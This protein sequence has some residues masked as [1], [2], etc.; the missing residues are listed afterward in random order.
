LTIN[1]QRKM[2]RDMVF[3]I[4]IS[5]LASH[6]CFLILPKVFEPW[7]AQIIDQ[8]FV[9]RDSIN[10][11]R[12][13]YDRTLIHVDINNSAVQQLDNFYLNRA[14][15][16]RVIN[17]LAAMKSAVEAFDF[18]FAARTNAKDDKRLIDATKEAGNV[19]FGLAFS[20]SDHPE[21]LQSG[22]KSREVLRYLDDVKWRVDLK[23]DASDFYS[24]GEPLITFPALSKS[25]RGIGFISIK[26]DRDGVFRRVPLL[27][28]Y[29][30]GFFPSFPFRVVCDYL[31]VTPDRIIVRP[32]KNITLKD[33]GK[34]GEKPHDIVIPIDSRG[35][36]IINFVGPWESMEH[37]SFSDIYRASED[38]DEMEMWKE[39]LAGKIVLVS[40]VST[41]SS[42]IGPVPTDLN[43]PL[44]GLHANVINTIL[45]GQF[46]TQL[47][48][49]DGVLIE[50][51]PMGVIFLLSLGLSSFVYPIGT[52][53]LAVA[54]CGTAAL[55][56]FYG[57]TIF[58]VLGP[59][60]LIVFATVLVIT[61]RYFAE[62]KEKAVYRKTFEAYFP[63]SIVKKLVSNPELISSKGQKKELTILFS[64]IKSFT[65]Y[66]A[67]LTPDQI[68]K[69]LNDYFEA[70]VDIVFGFEGTVDKYIGDGLMVFFGDP[71]PQP[72]HAIRCVR[73][74]IEMQRK[75]IKLAE[76]WDGEKRIPIQIRIGV[77][78]GEV[79]VG[80]MGS[81]RRLSYTV[82]GAP[83]NLA[84]R[85]E[86]NAPVGGIMI[87]RRTRDLVKDQVPTRSL[88]EIRVKGI[89]KPV[90]VY[91]VLLDGESADAGEPGASASVS[92]V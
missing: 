56:F 88:G 26:P 55:A 60:L 90:E 83:V 22:E 92:A 76:D 32:G 50:L 11:L 15:Y 72:D 3:L 82:L 17:N 4:M 29:N 27:V 41:A 75:V 38:R 64:D 45:T 84:Q 91:E 20:L 58:P 36:M 57:G 14:H 40:D 65:T 8:L 85:L 77:N 70:M 63:P 66:S 67:D 9:L 53:S 2:K 89:D 16:A 86:A 21:R 34:P 46:L 71:E 81:E 49:L 51:L 33:A 25:A 28:R 61:Y 5:F 13:R 37:R 79:V 42:D 19:Y 18:I 74:A 80:N 1:S 52:A 31:G 6:L 30:G 44:S 7:D 78:T 43:F 68:Q 59:L 35:D 39:K 24:G 73:A 62:E 87:S 47:S 69:S 48:S 10:R 12:P 54:Y 23:G